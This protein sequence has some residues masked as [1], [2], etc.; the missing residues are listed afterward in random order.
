[1]SNQHPNSTDEQSPSTPPSPK[2]GIS[3]RTIA[4]TA[5]ALVLCAGGIAY[6]CHH[7]AK[8]RELEQAQ[9]EQA[10]V[11]AEMEQRHKAEMELRAQR[12]RESIA[13][14]EKEIQTVE[15]RAEERSQ[16]WIQK[17]EEAKQ[18]AAELK[19]QQEEKERAQREARQ[20]ELLKQEEHRRL[21]EKL[22][23]QAILAAK[24]G[25]DEEACTLY[26]RAVDLGSPEAAHDLG[27]R[28]VLGKGVKKD[29]AKGAEF[30]KISAEGGYAE[31]EL[32]YGRALIEGRGVEKDVPT[33]MEWVEKA[34]AQGLQDARTLLEKQQTKER[35]LAR[36]VYPDLQPLID[37]MRALKC[38]HAVSAEQQRH[39][40]EML[41]QIRDGANVDMTTGNS[42]GHTALHYAC[43]IGS[44][45]ITRWLVNHGADVN[46]E[47]YNGDT[48]LDCVGDD[49]RTEI[50]NLLL[51]KGASSASASSRGNSSA[52]GSAAQM[53][54]FISSAYC[55]N[56]TD[57]V[58]QTRLK[59]LFS[60]MANNGA[61]VNEP[62]PGETNTALHYA[63]AMNQP[64]LVEWLL[65]HGAHI[66]ALNKRGESPAD[67]ARAQGSQAALEVLRAHG[68]N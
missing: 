29:L 53:L 49:H 9:A 17:Q 21:R 35:E 15:Q 37:R 40:L 26:L 61:D 67:C 55:R 12:L 60:R 65:Q 14:K 62:L 39:L 46:A 22:L 18:Q 13:S 64:V 20:R 28:Y 11:M 2:S 47:A 19:R 66:N 36:A 1:M 38:K 45:S 59:N 63:S 3:A 68:G 48:P 4:L 56:S 54:N 44:L 27:V 5:S 23:K 43:G 8:Q 7:Q 50:T 58:F 6:L 41:P 24:A 33:G 57:R 52:G 30:Y 51:Q 31:G 42:E 32:A 16:A 34:A 10:K 25:R